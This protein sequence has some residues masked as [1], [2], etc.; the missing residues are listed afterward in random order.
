MLRI[1]DADRVRLVT[2][3]RPEVL[4]AFN[5]ALCDALT[6]A[7][8]AA[9]ADPTIAVVV[10][11]GEGRAF[12]AGT[13]LLEMA[14]RTTGQFVEGQHGFV[15][16]IDEMVAFPKPLLCA[17]NGIGVGIGATMLGLADLVFMSTD[18]R[19][20][21]PF[22]SLAVAPEAASSVT[23]PHLVGRYNATWALMSS[24]WLS[25]QECERMGLAWRLCSP[26]ELLETTL[27]HARILAAKPIS[28]LVETKRTIVAP[29]RDELTAARRR[30]DDA[31]RRLLGTPAN[32]EALRAFAEKRPPDFAAIDAAGTG[33]SA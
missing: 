12:S 28:S 25:A 11:T 20:K 4:N 23:F 3:D 1:Q 7:L 24:E 29:M 27:A 30:E 16:L 22:T 19:L 10:L 31:Y 17:V 13:D 2:F 5:E 26:E 21:C 8:M 18:A 15:G 32:L 33:P 14:Q 9:A 6:E